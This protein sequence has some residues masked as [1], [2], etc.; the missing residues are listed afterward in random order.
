M[1]KVETPKAGRAAPEIL[2]PF[3]GKTAGAILISGP[4]VEGKS[5]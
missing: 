2:V 3:F 1:G 4:L 5:V